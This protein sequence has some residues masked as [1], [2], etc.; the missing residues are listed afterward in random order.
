MRIVY[1]VFGYGR[2]HATR[3]LSVLPELSARHAVLIVCGGDAW[4][5]ISPDYPALRIPTLRYVYQRRGRRSTWGTLR[6]NAAAVADVAFGGSW[7]RTVTAEIERFAPDVAL[8]DAEP[9]THRAARSLGVPRISFDHF[10]ILRYCRPE[11]APGDALRV[12]RDTALYRLLTGDPEAVIVSSFYDAPA[13]RPQVSCVPALLRR[14][15][16][17]ATPSS[18][19]HL[20]AYFNNGEHQFT[21]EI[22]AVLRAERVPVRIYGTRRQGREGHL[23]HRPFGPHFAEDLAS[24]RA[25]ISTAGN[26]LVGEALHLGKPILVS[27]EDSV[28]QRANALAVERLGVGLQAPGGRIGR[29][30]LRDFLD[31]HARFAERARA[32]SRDGRLEALAA[33]EGLARELAF[34]RRRMAARAWGYA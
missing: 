30:L 4:D 33:I 13:A 34:G 16:L 25:V 7:L 27:P 6:S 26:Q 18:G 14:E 24:C 19:E 5:A 10:G 2:G 21:D 29:G 32:L 3:A 12:A 15:I 11:L 28:E 17:G 9:F 8:C 1:G 23:L 22:A 31:D 20:L